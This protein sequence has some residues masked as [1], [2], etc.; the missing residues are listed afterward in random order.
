[1]HISKVWERMAL[2]GVGMIF[3]LLMLVNTLGRDGRL[4]CVF[5]R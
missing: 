3:F 2:F 4:Y 1:M 5:V